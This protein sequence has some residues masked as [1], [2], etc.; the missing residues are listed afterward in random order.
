MIFYLFYLIDGHGFPFE[1]NLII[2]LQN[3]N[4]Y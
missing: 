2:Y 3:C 1:S 4:Q